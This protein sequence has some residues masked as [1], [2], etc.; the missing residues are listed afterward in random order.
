MWYAIDNSSPIEV[1]RIGRNHYTSSWNPNGRISSADRLIFVLDGAVH[2]TVDGV[3]YNVSKGGCFFIRKG[4]LYASS[5]EES[6]DFYYIHFEAAH[7]RGPIPDEEATQELFDIKE[8]EQQRE[9]LPAEHFHKNLSCNIYIKDRLDLGG[10]F[11]PILLLISKCESSRYI[12]YPNNKMYINNRFEHLLLH[13]SREAMAEA[14]PIVEAPPQ[15]LKITSFIQENYT[16]PITLSSISSEFKLSKQYIIKLFKTHL[17]TTVTKYINAIR[18]ER[19]L[20]LLK[21]T[22]M[23]VNEIASFLGFN[24]S[25]YFCR[26]FKATYFITPT[27]YIKSD[28]SLDYK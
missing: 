22:S 3:D 18:L 16:N 27:E 1:L 13:L 20:E 5:I 23:N 28:I 10:Y 12:Y 24:S 8:R 4:S 15:L 21:N 26:L 9:P 17:G 25:Y 14:I 6:V 19:S 7:I 11:E 2:Y